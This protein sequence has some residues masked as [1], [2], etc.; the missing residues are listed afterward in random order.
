MSRTSAFSVSR[1]F[2]LFELL[3]V[4]IIAALI[5]LVSI[6]WFN[7]IRR[8]TQMR[9]T[10]MEISTTLVAARMKAVKRNVNVSVVFTP[11]DATFDYNR[12]ATIEPPP[13]VAPTPSANPLTDLLIPAKA[14]RFV[15]TS[16]GAI[17]FD[18]G[19]RRIAPVSPTPGAIVIEGP[20]GGGPV[21]QIT[22][23]TNTTGRVRVI[24][25]AVWQ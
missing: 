9:S 19:G 16:G 25:P 5:V 23:E 21:N 1:G 14:L 11:A 10:A 7:K 15:E 2:S 20:L 24:T 8:R 6:P 13:A 22:I 18:G 3:V 17:T 12:I 4:V